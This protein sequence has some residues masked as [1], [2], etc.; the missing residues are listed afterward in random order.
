MAD[1]EAKVRAAS[2]AAIGQ[3]AAPDQA[4]PALAKGLADR[5]DAVRLVAAARLRQ[6]GAASKGA[7]KELAAALADSDPSVAQAAAEALIRIGEPASAP[8]AAQLASSSPSARKLALA[9][10]AKI[11]PAAKSAIGAIEKCRNDS[12]PQIKQLA[13]AALARITNP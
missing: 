11:G 8:L 9:S 10:L 7:A 4:V 13:E 5:D 1:P 12:D 6:L 3:I 2:L